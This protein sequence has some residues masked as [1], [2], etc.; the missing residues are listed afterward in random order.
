[1]A[2]SDLCEG[3]KKINEKIKCAEVAYIEVKGKCM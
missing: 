3:V 1:V 2:N